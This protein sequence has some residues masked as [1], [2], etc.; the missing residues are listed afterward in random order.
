MYRPLGQ[1]L[2]STG[3]PLSFRRDG[4]RKELETG[5]VLIHT[6]DSD[7][8]DCIAPSARSGRYE[9][10]NCHTGQG[11]ILFGRRATASPDATENSHVLSW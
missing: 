2:V 6:V 4:I 11:S 1:H 8:L 9:P 10:R 5:I 7:P 3:P